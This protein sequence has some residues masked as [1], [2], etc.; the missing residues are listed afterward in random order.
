MKVIVIFFI[1]SFIVFPP[2]YSAEPAENA[3]LEATSE[4]KNTI[5]PYREEKEMSQQATPVV[6]VLVI[7]ILMVVVFMF[8]FKKKLS[9]VNQSS[10]KNIQVLE[11]KRLNARLTVFH[12][13]VKDKEIFIMQAGDNVTTLDMNDKIEDTLGA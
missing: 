13:K 11:I 5:I 6:L 1:L 7:F 4:N 9:L 2:A 8:L 12:L 3:E 10:E